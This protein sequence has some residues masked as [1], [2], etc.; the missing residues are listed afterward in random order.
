MKAIKRSF[1]MET[2]KLRTIN[3]IPW[4]EI[5]LEVEKSRLWF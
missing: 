5:A 4:M 2:I 3:S 1:D